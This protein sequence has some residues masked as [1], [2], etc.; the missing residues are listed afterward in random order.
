MHPR[1]R[2]I[3]IQRGMYR[4]LRQYARAFLGNLSP[5]L[6]KY[7]LEYLRDF[8]DFKSISAKRELLEAVQDAHLV[9]CGD[10][11]TLAQAQRTVLRLLRESVPRAN[12]R[13]IWIAFELLHASDNAKVRDYL[14]RK[15]TEEEFLKAIHFQKKWGFNWENY[16]ELFEFARDNQL[17]VTGINL[18]KKSPP[19]T[20]KQ[21][22]VFAAKVLADLSSANPDAWI[23]VLIGD[24]HLATPHL[25]A[26]LE[27]QFVKR[28]IKRKWAV[29]HQ[30]NERFYW[31]LVDKGLENLV[32]VVL[33]KPGVFCVMSTP[34][35]VKLQSHVKWNDILAEEIDRET[36]S[37]DTVDH[38]DEIQE[39]IDIIARFIGVD[40]K[41]KMNFHD[42]QIQGPLDYGFLEH[43]ERSGKYTR[44]QI[45]FLAKALT[46]FGNYFIPVE[47]IIYLSSLSVNHA[48]ELASI[49]LHAKLSRA[50]HWFEDPVRDFYPMV[51]VEALGFLGS[52][53]INHKRK[54][55][56]PRDLESLANAKPTAE[57]GHREAI[58][59]AVLALN[60][61]KEEER[62]SKARDKNGF[63]V[64]FSRG[65][66]NTQKTLLYHKV[67]K[68]LGQ[69]LGHGL[70]T[71]VMANRLTREELLQLFSHSFPSGQESC[72][73]YLHWAERLD[74]EG[75]RNVTKSDRL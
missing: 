3:R 7:Y 72:Q 67:A 13:K 22:D 58:A 41:G 60:H 5:S 27:R 47:N 21:R 8:H 30:N 39:W 45:R 62:A 2:L 38:A 37:P 33:M 6:K 17:Q 44:P 42:F 15:M 64:K 32:D 23:F 68:L 43:L 35:W 10:Y 73:L 40:P 49:Y 52:K 55:N 28:S 69:L 54:C 74:Q 51:W 75:F 65:L 71:A 36:L 66:A 31:K 61:L 70:Y 20:L 16:R 19:P 29:I 9:L 12:D 1:T 48:S 4:R 11:H 14:D 34:P 56:G 53:V 63:E 18:A 50:V 25:P 46:E 59:A 26:E 57:K 24:L